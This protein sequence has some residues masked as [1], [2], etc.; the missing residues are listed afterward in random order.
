MIEVLPD[1]PE[2]VTG[3]RVS[4]KL[5]GDDIREFRPTMQQLLDTDEIRFVEVIDSDY[6][7]FGPGGLTEDLKQGFGVVFQHHSS[8]KRMAVVTD[9]EWIAHALHAL[10]WMVPGELKLFGLDELEQAKEWSAG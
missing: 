6:R 2:G 10:A 4:G 1:T 3:I 5:T 8:F 7:G 9:K